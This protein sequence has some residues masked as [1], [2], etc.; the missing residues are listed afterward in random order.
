M[1]LQFRYIYSKTRQIGGLLSCEK[2]VHVR[3]SISEISNVLSP[4]QE[5][6]LVFGD[7]QALDARELRSLAEIIACS[8]LI[9]VA[10]A[11]LPH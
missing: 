1:I 10:G 4:A 8:K 3:I 5:T 11:E 7:Y 9:P 6:A 2:G